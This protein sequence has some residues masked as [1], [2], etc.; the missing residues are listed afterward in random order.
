MQPQIFQ[1]KM[2]EMLEN[3]MFMNSLQKVIILLVLILLFNP[4][5]LLWTL[6]FNDMIKSTTKEME[7]LNIK[8]TTGKIFEEKK[9]SCTWEKLIALSKMLITAARKRCYFHHLFK[10]AKTVLETLIKNNHIYNLN[11]KIYFIFSCSPPFIS[12]ANSFLL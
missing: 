1:C 11:N 5:P 10:A 2:K 12:G 3:G 4:Q 8:K 6:F 7:T 9:S